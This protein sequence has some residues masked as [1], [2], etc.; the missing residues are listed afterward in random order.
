MKR[1]VKHPP[2]SWDL[3]LSVDHPPVHDPGHDAVVRVVHLQ[4][5]PLHELT[6]NARM[7]DV[8]PRY[9]SLGEFSTVHRF[10]TLQLGFYSSV[11]PSDSL[12]MNK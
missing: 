9:P 1:L 7:S 10:Q 6:Q 2:P 4:S 11:T 12:T 3:T 8:L 5:D